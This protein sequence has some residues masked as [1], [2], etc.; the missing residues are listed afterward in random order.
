MKRG[1][2]PSVGFATK[3]ATMRYLPAILL[4]TM[5]LSTAAQAGGGCTTEGYQKLRS[6]DRVPTR[7]CQAQLLGR[8]A[9]SHGLRLSD[10]Q[11]LRQPEARKRICDTVGGDGRL[12]F[13]CQLVERQ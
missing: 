4:S 1:M 11:I 7:A 13:A 12:A 5:A 2:D 8:V 9:R 10:A 6:G 3:G